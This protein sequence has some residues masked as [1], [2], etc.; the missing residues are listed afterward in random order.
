MIRL[1]LVEQADKTVLWNLLQKYFYEMSACYDLEMDSAGNY[2]YSYFD[3]YFEDANRSA[4]FITDNNALIGFVMIN[5]HSYIHDTIDY[6]IAEFTIFPKYRRKRYAEEAVRRIFQERRGKWELKF[7]GHNL[8]AS[9]FWMKTTAPYRP[10]VSSFGDTE[11]VLSF[12]V[13]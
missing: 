1:K 4:Y 5:D 3:A 8:P 12:L 10:S 7:S 13:K 2:A 11:K 6:A 9:A